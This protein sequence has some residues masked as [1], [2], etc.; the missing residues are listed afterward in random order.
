MVTFDRIPIE[1]RWVDVYCS[2][3]S[4]YQFPQA[5][6]KFLKERYSKPTIYRWV[7]LKK[8]A[9]PYAVYIGEAENLPQRIGNYLQAHPT[10]KTNY[11]MKAEFE[12]ALANGA[13]VRLQKIEFTPFALNNVLV[14]ESALHNAYIRKMLEN[15]LCADNDNINCEL[16]NL[17]STPIERRRRKAAATRAGKSWGEIFEEGHKD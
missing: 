9:L 16:R 17:S 13:E 4:P 8:S 5:V 7:F 2:E 14:I 3:G 15:F 12:R 10:Q 1:Y 6:S 11:R